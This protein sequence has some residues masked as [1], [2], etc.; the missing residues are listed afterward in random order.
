[1]SDNATEKKILNAATDVFQTKGMDG[2][3]MQEIA[4]KAG[5]N[6]A[7]L[8]Y[9]Y[10]SKQK[11]FEAVFSGAIKLIAPR[12]LK[13]IESDLHLFDKIRTFTDDY[14]SFISKHS[15]IP[16]FIINELNRHPDM[17]ER[18]FAGKVN[19]EIE[20]KIVRQI[21]DMVTKGEIRPIKPEQLL[22]DVISLSFFPIMA[23]PLLGGI[24]QKNDNSYEKMIEERKTHVA[25]F[26]IASIKL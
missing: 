18:L 3:R 20:Q 6:K 7:M 1:M 9:Y 23:K 19:M 8:H 17:F 26:I 21:N 25:D 2:A 11:L 12:I 22:L 14:I 24:L 13:I 4:D 5:I 10:R 15:Y 16:L